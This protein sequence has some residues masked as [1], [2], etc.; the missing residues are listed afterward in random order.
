MN[1]LLIYG[2]ILVLIT[3]VI[4]YTTKENSKVSPYKGC[5]YVANNKECTKNFLAYSFIIPNELGHSAT[6]GFT[7]FFGAAAPAARGVVPHKLGTNSF[8]VNLCCDTIENRN[9]AKHE[10]QLIELDANIQLLQKMLPQNVKSQIRRY[11]TQYDKGPKSYNL[12]SRLETLEKDQ[13]TAR[14]FIKSINMTLDKNTKKIQELGRV[15]AG[16]A[17]AMKKSLPSDAECKMGYVEVNGKCYPR[18]IPPQKGVKKMAAAYPRA[19]PQKAAA[20][21]GFARAMPQREVATQ[22]MTALAKSP[23]SNSFFGFLGF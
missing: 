4:I 19:M 11:I 13:N 2:I 6:A 21:T 23:K 17:M 22:Q 5:T 15:A 16:P 20:V 1:K 12:N 9:N 18:A 8:A 10:I 7:P 14:N 3:I